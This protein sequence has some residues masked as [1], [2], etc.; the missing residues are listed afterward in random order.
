MDSLYRRRIPTGHVSFDELYV[1]FFGDIPEEQNSRVS[2]SESFESLYQKYHENA[3]DVSCQRMFDD[4]YLKYVD[5]LRVFSGGGD[6][7]DFVYTLIDDSSNDSISSVSDKSTHELTSQKY[8]N[9]TPYQ[10]TQIS[11]KGNSYMSKINSIQKVDDFLRLLPITN[12]PQNEV[13]ISCSSEVKQNFNSSSFSPKSPIIQTPEKIR[14][15]SSTRLDSSSSSKIPLIIRNTG[16]SRILR[17]HRS[18]SSG[19]NIDDLPALITPANKFGNKLIDS[20]KHKDNN[21]KK[22]NV[23]ETN[24]IKKFSLINNFDDEDDHS[25]KKVKLNRSKKNLV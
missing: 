22:S 12:P 23:K 25:K 17:N 10:K 4:L 21:S 7:N 20:L 5:K 2:Q 9:V 14:T 18:K 19:N 8:S 13:S 16:S 1:K 15:R 6:S 11:Q 24:G 3:K